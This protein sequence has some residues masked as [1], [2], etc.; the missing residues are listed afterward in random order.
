MMMKVVLMEM[1]VFSKI[2]SVPMKP[3]RKL[4]QNKQIYKHTLNI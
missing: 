1:H 4:L 2:L 3:D